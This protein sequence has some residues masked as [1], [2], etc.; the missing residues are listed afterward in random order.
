MITLKSSCNS[1]TFQENVS[2]LQLVQK[3]EYS[4]HMYTEII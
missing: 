1:M 3:E 4:V 2:T